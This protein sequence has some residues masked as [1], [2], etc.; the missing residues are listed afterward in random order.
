MHIGMPCEPNWPQ[1]PRLHR[2]R[3]SEVRSPGRSTRRPGRNIRQPAEIQDKTEPRQVHLRCT[4]RKTTGVRRLQARDQGE[5]HEDRHDRPTRQTRVSA[6]C[7]EAGRASR[8]SQPLHPPIGREGDAPISPDA[9]EPHLP[10]GQGGG[11]RTPL[12]E[13]GATRSTTT[14]R[15]R[16]QRTHA[17]LRHGFRACRQRRHGRR[18]TGGGKGAPGTATGVLHQRGPHRVAPAIPAIPETGIRGLQSKA[19]L[20]HYFQEHP[21]TVVSSAPLQDIIRNRE[22]TGRVAKWAVKIGVHNIKYEPRKSI[23]SQALAD[24]I[25]DWEEA[26]QSEKLPHLHYW[27]L[28]FDGSKNADGAGAGIVLTSPKGDKLRYVLCLDFTPCT[29]NMAEYE[30]LLHGMQAA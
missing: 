27:S 14:R 16:R 13:E 7:P 11:R 9:K 26:Q 17:G 30:A 3:G 28:H 2:R 4:S 21:I 24:F 5:P 8:G 22:A 15:P 29:N 25:A 1:Y 23:K 12:S 10:V 19:A 18:A 6:R 20:P